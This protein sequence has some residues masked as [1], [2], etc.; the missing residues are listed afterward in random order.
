MLGVELRG[1]L[2]YL[3]PHRIADEGG[4]VQVSM[5]LD[6]FT[7]EI[8]ELHGHLRADEHNLSFHPLYDL[9]ITKVRQFNIHPRRFIYG[10]R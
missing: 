4:D 9:S 5:H 7:H 3:L 6:E 10:I 1:L 2:E 8:S